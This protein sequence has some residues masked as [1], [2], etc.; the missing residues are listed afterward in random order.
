MKQPIKEMSRMIVIALITIINIGVF[1][2]T[3]ILMNQDYN[4]Q[5]STTEEMTTDSLQPTEEISSIDQNTQMDELSPTNE[6][7]TNEAL[8]L[9]DELQQTEASR[10]RDLRGGY[11]MFYG[12]WEIAK[13]VGLD[14]RYPNYPID[15]EWAKSL[16]GRRVSY[17]YES[18]KIDD[19]EILKD[20]VYTIVI[21]PVMENKSYIGGMPTLEE[22]GI[23]GNYFAFI[24]IYNVHD[25]SGDLDGREFYVKD[26]N[27]LVLFER[28]VYYE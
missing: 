18:F 1:S 28:A 15:M 25:F 7:P 9:T 24:Y 19:V 20:P 16:I 26:D 6:A 10:E 5:N 14:I 12:E 13:I 27:T 8:Q 11:K 2:A 21:S 3:L 22:I 23:T 17:T 4:K